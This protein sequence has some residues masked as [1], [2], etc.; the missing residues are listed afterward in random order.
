MNSCLVRSSL[1]LFHILLSSK[2]RSRQVV[3]TNPHCSFPLLQIN[4]V[5]STTIQMDTIEVLLHNVSHSDLVLAS[6]SLERRKLGRPNFSYYQPVARQILECVLSSTETNLPTAMY[7][8]S[9]RDS[10]SEKPHTIDNIVVPIG[11][12]FSQH[13]LLLQ[14]SP[15][16]RFH[17]QGN[18][19]SESDDDASCL[20]TVT[21]V[22]FP[23]LA[24]LIARWKEFI[25]E[26][27]RRPMP[28]L[29]LISGVGTPAYDLDLDADASADEVNARADDNST[30]LTA[31]VM[32]LWLTR[33]WPELTV[34]TVHAQSNI[35]RYDDNIGFVLR[36]LLPRLD[37]LRDDAVTLVKRGGTG[38]EWRRHMRVSFAYADGA[39]ARVNAINAALTSYR[40]TY[41]HFW[42]LKT[43][44]HQQHVHSFED[45]AIVPSIPTEDA[46]EPLDLLVKEMLNF[47]ADFDKTVS[48]PDDFLS[49]D[50][51]AFWMRKT[52]KPVLAVLL[53]AP[54]RSRS[55]VHSTTSTSPLPAPS[56]SGYRVY[57]GTNMEVSMPTGSLCAERNVIGSALASDLSL[58]REDLVAVAV[59]SVQLPSPDALSAINRTSSSSSPSMDR[60][61][62]DNDSDTDEHVTVAAAAAPTDSGIGVGVGLGEFPL[63]M[64]PPR[65]PPQSQSQSQSYTKNG[66]PS[67]CSSPLHI[68]TA[69]DLMSSSSSGIGGGSSSAHTSPNS[70]NVRLIRQFS[71]RSKTMTDADLRGSDLFCSSSSLKSFPRVM[72]SQSMSEYTATNSSSNSSSHHLHLHH[73]PVQGTTLYQGTSGGTAASQ[74]LLTCPVSTTA[75][76][77]SLGKRR[78]PV[79]AQSFQLPSSAVRRITVEESD[80]NPLRPCG[81]CQEW[82]RKVAEVN[83]RFRVLT[84]TDSACKG[85]FI[86]P[87][88]GT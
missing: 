80:M 65:S 46:P 66:I 38:G 17:Y 39:S 45:F 78:L 81:A 31:E 30:Q 47:K 42:Q 33:V 41:M 9:R 87:V 59:L 71:T 56:P 5:S 37:E 10:V 34:H 55:R 24:V 62:N 64:S 85:V 4:S 82:L 60:N 77:L 73:H 13:P 68:T 28:H 12:D 43:F 2:N 23:L 35:F 61:D 54:A 27:D 70:R 11:F 79:T 19:A 7:P 20:F 72:S 15:Q 67:F 1:M 69:L 26:I 16:L 25:N 57:R 40:P 52:R 86:E 44:W 32:K 51:A 74:S 50:L 18:Q 75:P 14:G 49:H 83:P 6:Q 22:Y 21:S 8:I 48:G 63:P 53:V 58:R 76:S 88:G 36:E 3:I 29:F 84:F